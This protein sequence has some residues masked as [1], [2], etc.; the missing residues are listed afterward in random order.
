MTRSFVPPNDALLPR[1]GLQLLDAPVPWIG[2]HGFK[3]FCGG[4]HEGMIPHVVFDAGRL[5]ALHA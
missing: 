3:D 5:T 4:V 1:H 2:L